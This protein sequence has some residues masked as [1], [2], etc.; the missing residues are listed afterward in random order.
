MARGTARRGRGR[1]GRGG[2][3]GRGGGGAA[4]VAAAAVS[5][6]TQVPNGEAEI[7]QSRVVG[8]VE[9]SSQSDLVVESEVAVGTAAST[10]FQPVVET[11]TTLGID[12]T[13]ETTTDVETRKF[14]KDMITHDGNQERVDAVIIATEEEEEEEEKLVSD[15]HE[16]QQGIQQQQQQQQIAT[17][18]DAIGEDKDGEDKNGEANDGGKDIGGEG[19]EFD[20][21]AQHS[22][23]VSERR[24][25]KRLEVFV[26]GL[27]KDTS[28]ED[29]KRLFQQVGD[30]VEV[31]LMRNSQTGKNKGYAFIRYATTAM[32]KRAAEELQ[33][34]EIN[35]RPCGVLPSE[36]N[37]TLFLGNISKSWKK[38]MVL[39]ALRDMG[40][41]N[42]EELTL[43]EDPQ[44]E[45]VN[46]GFSFIEF[47]THKEALKAFRRL[48][49]TDATFGTDRSA[50]VA[51]AQ[52][53]NEPDE[54]TMSQVKSVFVD[55]MPPAWDEEKV[56]E[57]FGK[58]GEIDR[59]VLARNMS[60]A[61]RKDFGFVNYVEREA[62][63]ACIDAISNSGIVDGEIKIKMKVMLAKP[64]VKSKPA[65][66]GVRGG[67]PLGFKGD[68]RV[69]SVP[70]QPGRGGGGGREKSRRHS[71]NDGIHFGGSGGIRGG[72]PSN[73]N[74]IPLYKND[75]G[76]RGRGQVGYGDRHDERR[77]YNSFRAA[78]GRGSLPTQSE[79][80]AERY[81]RVQG[82]RGYVGGGYGGRRE[83]DYMVSGGGDIG[84]GGV[85][86]GHSGR[87][88][89]PAA[90]VYG[91]HDRP[92]HE[93]YGGSVRDYEGLGIKRSY[94]AMEE[95][96]KNFESQRGIPRARLE[97]PE[98]VPIQSVGVGQF[99]GATMYADA[100]R[101]V[102]LPALSLVTYG[103]MYN[104]NGNRASVGRLPEQQQYTPYAVPQAVSVG[105]GVGQPQYL[106]LQHVSS[107]QLSTQHVSSQHVSTQQ[108][109]MSGM[110]VGGQQQH[111][112]SPQASIPGPSI[113]G[114]VEGGTPYSIYDAAPQPT[115][116]LQTTAPQ[117]QAT[118][119]FA[120]GYAPTSYGYAAG[121]TPATAY[122]TSAGYTLSQEY[123][124]VA[125][126]L[127]AQEVNAATSYPTQSAYTAQYAV[128][129]QQIPSAISGFTVPGAGQQTYY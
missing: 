26:G 57:H 78:H 58:F 97:A 124:G 73:P 70:A 90:L 79:T 96:A 129:P 2:G 53:L 123:M 56:R 114:Q 28:E 42:I 52:P 104:F 109:S 69:G 119:N 92:L 48:Q 38:E 75:F 10:D 81:D 113:G 37:D 103:L 112:P 51:W 101:F 55:G 95:E 21:E 87:D 99:G 115:V 125:A 1:G 60:A 61:K 12:T 105:H 40:I 122:T 94:S 110:M 22:L 82:G 74:T 121:Y 84:G 14:G 71:G 25:H 45:G 19:G 36:E 85:G 102:R 54:E 106:P 86:V 63:M 117:H 8:E 89:I 67:Y 31:R 16:V 118:H 46:R 68:H 120:T 33:H 93:R 41:N 4:A 5:S 44:L 39:D 116:G 6:V 91:G 32:A 7:E 43:M 72:Y 65:K 13:T 24:K 3:R 77:G 50:K 111:M 80:Y 128:T 107:Q 100:S 76:G 88:H 18:W 29:L 11:V 17:N 98:P 108:A 47:S 126:A 27:D 35:G 9:V 20:A 83:Y 49:Q 64:Q 30:V 62:A 34:I 15:F 66:G 23:P 127:P 59:I